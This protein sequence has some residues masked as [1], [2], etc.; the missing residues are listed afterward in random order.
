MASVHLC[1]LPHPLGEE[2]RPEGDKEGRE[3]NTVVRGRKAEEVVGPWVG[4]SEW[5]EGGLA[6]GA[7]EGAGAKRDISKLT[8]HSRWTDLGLSL[9]LTVTRSL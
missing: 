9:S 2:G 4:T 8:I 3:T 6:L 1:Y 5:L 7:G